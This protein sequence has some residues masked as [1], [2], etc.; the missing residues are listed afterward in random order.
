MHCETLAYMLH[1][2]DRPRERVQIGSRKVENPFVEI[3]SGMATLGRENGFGWDNEFEQ[4]EVWVPAFAISAHK[5]TNGEYLDFVNAGGP[6]PHFWM[7]QKEG[8]SWRGMFHTYPLPLDWPV[9][10]THSQ[11][12][13]YAEWKG[14]A[15]PT[16]AEWHR[17]AEA[18]DLISGNFGCLGWEPRAVQTPASAVSGLSGDAWEWTSTVF[19]PFDGF[20]PFPF[21]KGYSANFFDGQHYVLKGASMRTPSKLV[22]SSFRNWFRP[23]Y[24]YMY[25][26]FRLVER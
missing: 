2:I 21:Y 3:P 25:A 8:W 22:R 16:E 24:P 19:H 7:R 12:S 4:H 10:V 9:F 11:A 18:A 13:D 26:G 1:N 20:E 5:V 17:A 6:V 14:K 15:L 23:D